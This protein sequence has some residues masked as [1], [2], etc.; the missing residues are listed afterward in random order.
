M[1]MYI[2]KYIPGMYLIHTYIHAHKYIEMHTQCKHTFIIM[3]Y[4]TRHVIN[5]NAAMEKYII[6]LTT[7][8]SGG[9]TY[10]NNIHAQQHN[11]IH[12]QQHNNIHAQQHNNTHNNNNTTTHMHNNTTTYMHNNTTY[13][14]NNTTTHTTTTQQHTY[15]TTHKP[16]LIFVWEEC[17][18]ENTAETYH[19]SSNA[20]AAVNKWIYFY[21][22]MILFHLVLCAYLMMA[23]VYVGGNSDTYDMTVPNHSC[24]SCEKNDKKGGKSHPM[25]DKSPLRLI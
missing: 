15:T 3:K 20:I 21:F 8:M 1:H 6:A 2:D 17:F 25:A 22:F 18:C 9:N 7:E 23:V 12:A 24:V 16:Q 14:H 10:S 19:H 4:V 5:T 11:N 13:M